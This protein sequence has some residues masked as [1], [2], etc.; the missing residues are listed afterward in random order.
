MSGGAGIPRPGNTAVAA[1]GHGALTVRIDPEETNA[2]LAEPH[3]HSSSS[4]RSRWPS[5]R[6]GQPRGRSITPTT[7]ANTS[8]ASPGRAGSGRVPFTAVVI[9]RLRGHRV[10]AGRGGAPLVLARRDGERTAGEDAR[11]SC[12]AGVCCLV[13][14]TSPARDKRTSRVA[15]RPGRVQGLL[16]GQLLCAGDRLALPSARPRSRCCRVGG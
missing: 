14:D 1:S 4:R 7:T 8:S 12:R 9:A 6:A 11:I 13:A 3:A 15:R 5:R 2:L 16:A 10:R